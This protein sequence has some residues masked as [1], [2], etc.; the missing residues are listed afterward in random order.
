VSEKWKDVIT[1]ALSLIVGSLCIGGAVHQALDGEWTVALLLTALGI[2]AE[3]YALN[4]V[5]DV[6]RP[7]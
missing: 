4:I 3:V 7:Q 5:D 1:A 6:R 2:A